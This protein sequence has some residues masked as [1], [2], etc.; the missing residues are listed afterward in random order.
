MELLVVEERE[1]ERMGKLGRRLGRVKVVGTRGRD[2]RTRM[3]VP[4][5][6]ERKVVMARI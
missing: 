2:M 4:R 3:L 5:R 1:E 6:E